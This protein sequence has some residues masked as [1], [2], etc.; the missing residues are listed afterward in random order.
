MAY[1]I[2]YDTKAG[3]FE[4]RQD[5]QGSLFPM[6]LAVCFGL[7]V[8]LTFCFWEAGADFIR[9]VLIPGEDAATLEALRNLTADMRD[10]IPL[11]EAVEAFC[12]EL[13]HGAN[14]AH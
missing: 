9:S 14:A 4:I 5:R 10:G 6:L 11:G 13:I 2:E 7:F 8:L 1:R 3:K 12:R